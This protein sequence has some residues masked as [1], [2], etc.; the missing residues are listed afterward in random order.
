ML[1]VYMISTGLPYL[2]HKKVYKD[3]FILHDESKN[4]PAE[5]AEKDEIRAVHGADIDIEDPDQV[6]LDDGL[7]NTDTRQDMMMT[8]GQCCPQRYQP[9][10][11]IRNYFGEKISLYFAWVGA[12]IETLWIPTA[13][14]LCVFVYGLYLR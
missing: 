5:K 1:F 4:D 10:W 2:L 14:G 8:W 6:D 9:L 7:L 11:K 3:A 13:F 12:W